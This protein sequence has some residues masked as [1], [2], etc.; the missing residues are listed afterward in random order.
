VPRHN[1]IPVRW[2]L[3]QPGGK[4]KESSDCK[5]E[6]KKILQSVKQ[7]SSTLQGVKTYLHYMMTIYDNLYDDEL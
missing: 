7:N 5:G 1:Y 3:V 4:C 2:Q 6:S